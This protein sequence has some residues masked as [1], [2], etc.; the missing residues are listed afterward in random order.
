[1]F[2]QENTA[3]ATQFR[4][5]PLGPVFYRKQ[6]DLNYVLSRDDQDWHPISEPQ[7]QHLLFELSR[8]Q[9]DIGALFNDAPE[10]ATDYGVI[11]YQGDPSYYWLGSE[12]FEL[13]KKSSITK[14]RTYGGNHA[15]ESA[16]AVIATRPPVEEPAR[17]VEGKPVYTQLM[18]D[19]GELPPIGSEVRYNTASQGD[20]TGVVK[21]IEVKPS[22]TR[23]VDC[24]IFVYFE[25]NA[26]L[27]N[28]VF[29]IDTRSDE[30]K[31]IDY[32][33]YAYRK[34]GSMS[35]VLSEI[36]KGYVLDVEYTGK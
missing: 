27:I 22:A 35:D 20:V 10:W 1:M 17:V 11:V 14:F 30:E 19:N 36:K 6:G 21:R 33:D 5:H 8:P 31:T 23:S 16:F 9:S 3:E 12:G 24:R 18:R 13:V 26:R 29:P 2:T 25:N 4:S 28:E 32:M 15:V 7:N 34:G